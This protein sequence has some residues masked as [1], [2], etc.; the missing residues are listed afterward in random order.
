ERFTAGVDRLIAGG[1]GIE[2]VARPQLSL[3]AFRAAR[4]AGESLERWNRRNATFLA[5]INARQR[6]HLSS[7]LLPVSDGQAFTLRVCVLSFR[8]HADRIDQCL[9]DVEAAL[10][11]VA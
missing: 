3:V 1:A 6:V 9:E 7:T 5:A 4:A 2:L 10:S 8:T 11:S